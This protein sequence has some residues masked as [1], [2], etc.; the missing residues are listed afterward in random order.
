LGGYRVT[1][2]DASYSVTLGY[3]DLDADLRA[4]NVTVGWTPQ[5][6][7]VEDLSDTGVKLFKLTT[8]TEL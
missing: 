3:K 4:L 7:A 1:A 2:N 6:L 8:Y 5:G